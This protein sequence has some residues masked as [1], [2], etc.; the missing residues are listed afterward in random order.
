MSLLATPPMSRRPIKT[1]IGEFNLEKIVEAIRFE[2]GRGGQVYFLHNR[3]ESL[4]EVVMMIRQQLPSL[5]IESIH[6]QMDPILIED[7]M[8]RFVHQGIQVLVSTTL[9]ENGIDIPNVNTIIIDRAD[10]YGISQ[11]YQL[12]G[13]VGRS[14]QEGFASLFYPA[15]TALSEVAIKR[16]KVISENTSLGSFKL[17]L[18]IWN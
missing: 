4:N 9:I 16:L 7:V 17:P 13:R 14:D 12:R 15:Q 3:I 5:L 2:I 11:L 6:G 8:H 1:I 10:R 18:K